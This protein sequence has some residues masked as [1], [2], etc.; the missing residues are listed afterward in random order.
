L[1]DLDWSTAAGVFN[2][3]FRARE[4]LALPDGV[5]SLHLLELR[6]EVA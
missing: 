3:R 5:R 1:A 4:A 2:R 6:E